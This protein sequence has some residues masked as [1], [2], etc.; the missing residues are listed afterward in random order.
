MRYAPLCIHSFPLV[1][2]RKL[3]DALSFN[4]Q[5]PDYTKISTVSD[6][7]RWCR[8]H[9]GF[10]QQ[11]VADAI[12]ISR[13]SYADFERGRLS[14]YP[15]DLLDKVATLYRI[16]VDDL[17]DDYNRFLY[18]GQE[19]QIK[20][21]RASLGLNKKEFAQFL[22]IDAGLLHTWETGQKQLGFRSWEK[23]FKNFRNQIPK[24]NCKTKLNK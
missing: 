16:P 14:C 17:L 2:P 8:H 9:R 12:G 21:Y 11:E 22:H 13:N 10:T 15:K 6:R 18:D 19:K 7:L 4:K 20:A 24:I 3:I 23:Y 1:A 5:H